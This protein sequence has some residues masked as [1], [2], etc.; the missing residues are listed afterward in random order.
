MSQKKFHKGFVTIH[1]IKPVLTIDKPIDVGFSIPDLS[2]YLIY[3]FHYKYIK[4]KFSAN[5]LFTDT[6]TV[7]F[8]KL[9]QI[10]FMKLFMRKK[11]VCF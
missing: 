9:K 3:K 7:L 11:C 8:T 6:G 1:E 4:G 5:L 10:M 2:K